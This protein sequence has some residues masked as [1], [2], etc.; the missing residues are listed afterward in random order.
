MELDILEIIWQPI[1]LAVGVVMD[2]LL[3]MEVKLIPIETHG[4][5]Y[6]E[7]DVIKVELNMSTGSLTF[8][9]N[10]TSRCCLFCRYSKPIILLHQLGTMVRW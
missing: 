2:T 5:T 1:V 6:G 10:N 9:K 7:G 8:Y 3:K 4:P